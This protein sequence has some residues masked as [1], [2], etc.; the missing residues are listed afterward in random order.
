MNTAMS[1]K[2]L[3]Y[4]VDQ[5]DVVIGSS[6]KD[7]GLEHGWVRRFARIFIINSQG[8]IFLQKRAD[9]ERIAPGRW[10]ESTGGH[11]DYGESYHEAALR[12][13]REE[14]GVSFAPGQ[15][16]EVSY[17]YME[18]NVGEKIMPSWNKG[19]VVEHEGPFVFQEE[20]VQGGEWFGP[21][22]VLELVTKSPESCAPGLVGFV[23]NTDMM[24]L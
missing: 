20:E 8:E 15:P 18:E 24:N 4:H 7:E 13:A 10:D 11:V 5:D 14:L 21:A 12:E 17:F 3:I 6:T 16:H 2:E 1:D 22:G 23:Q 19:F 9:N